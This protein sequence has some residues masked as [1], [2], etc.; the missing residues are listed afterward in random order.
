MTFSPRHRK[1]FTLLEIMIVVT[2]VSLL[3]WL[4]LFVIGRIKDKAVHSLL[5][6]NLRQLYQAKEFYYA[7]TGDIKPVLVMELIKQ[8]YLRK[9]VFESLYQHHSLETKMGWLYTGSFAVG[10]PVFARH[11]ANSRGVGPVL[12]TVWYP[13]PPSTAST[14]LNTTNQSVPAIPSTQQPVVAQPPVV[15]TPPIVNPTVTGPADNSPQGQTALLP[16]GPGNS[17]FGHS[18]GNSANSPQGQ[19]NLPPHGPGNSDSGH[20]HGNSAN[21]PGHNKK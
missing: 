17:D 2:I 12:E 4:A 8:D 20:S 1:G 9:S 14:N 18:Q 19:S 15:V 3:S 10:E 7:Q 5:Q 16:H 6:N 21:A 11:Y 13:E